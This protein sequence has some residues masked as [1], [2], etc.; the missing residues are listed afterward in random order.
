MKHKI[1]Q[2]YYYRPTE[3]PK[4]R[5]V[6]T[7]KTPTVAVPTVYTTGILDTQYVKVRGV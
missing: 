1:T 7:P 3:L 6:R 5:G 4:V 2:L